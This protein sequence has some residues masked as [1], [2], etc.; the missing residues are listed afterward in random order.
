METTPVL[1]HRR[2]VILVVVSSLLLAACGTAALSRWSATRP[3]C[4]VVL[5]KM[6]VSGT[7]IDI[8]FNYQCCPG[9]TVELFQEIESHSPAV[10]STTLPSN[11]KAQL[12][13]GLG[14]TQQGGGSRSQGSNRL[15]SVKV[16][17]KEGTE[18]KLTQTGTFLICEHE[19]HYGPAENDFAVHRYYLIVR[20]Q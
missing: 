8:G 9:N 1:T 15:Q 20:R 3:R 10:R 19:D 16:H 4:V 12:R 13:F 7:H 5:K 11:P 14:L 2:F 6:K 18:W 17:I